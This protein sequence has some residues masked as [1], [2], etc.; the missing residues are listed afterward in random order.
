MNRGHSRAIGETLVDMTTDDVLD[1]LYERRVVMA[2]GKLDGALGDAVA[3]R[4]IALDAESSDPIELV[5]D[6][7]DADLDPAFTLLDVCE[8]LAS[9]LTVLVASRLT[10]AGLVLLTGRHRRLARPHA[11]LRLSEPQIEPASGATEAIA[12]VVEEHRRRVALLI[13]R[14]AEKTSRPSPLVADEMSRGIYL[15]SDEAVAYGLLDDVA[16]RA[17]A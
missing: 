6:C 5:L 1:R 13:E 10:G 9:P 14:L 8:A 4:L 7:P 17:S 11:T 12:R 16:R 15:T 2:N 3:T